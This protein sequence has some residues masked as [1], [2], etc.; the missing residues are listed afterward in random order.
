[1]IKELA[2]FIEEEVTLY[3]FNN[4]VI[5]FKILYCLL[6][7]KAGNWVQYFDDEMKKQA[8]EFMEKNLKNTDMRYP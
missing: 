8:E 5:K 1:M 6:S 2:A 7:G 3:L 4:N